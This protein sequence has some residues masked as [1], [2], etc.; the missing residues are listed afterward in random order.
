MRYLP[1]LIL[2]I[3]LAT[4]ALGKTIPN[5]ASANLVLGQSGFTT[6]SV[7]PVASPYTLDAP[8]CV[9]VDPA[10]GKVFVLEYNSCRVLR[11]PSASSLRNGAPAEAVFG[12]PRFSSTASGSGDTG[13]GSLAYSIFFDHRGR[14]WVSVYSQHRVLMYEA[15]STRTSSVLADRVY[16]QPNFTTY[17]TGTT[18]STMINPIGVC[19]DKQDHLWV[20]DYGNNR[21]LRFD[22][23]TDKPSGSAADGVLGQANFNTGSSG[24]S[25]TKLSS[26]GHIAVSPSGS[27]FV[28]DLFNHRIVRF[29]NAAQLVNGAG[30]SAVFGQADFTS[31]TPGTSATKY[32]MPWG[33]CCADDDSIWITELSKPRVLRIS[34]ATTKPTNAA[35][36]GVIGQADFITT[37]PGLD[38]RNIAANPYSQPCVDA[39]S[40]LWLPDQMNNRVLRFPP[41]LTKPGLVVKAVAKKVTKK[42]LKVSG[43]ASDQYGVAKVQYKLGNGAAKTASGT[44]TWSF[45]VTLAEGKNKLTV[46]SIDSVG[47]QSP[48]K[49]IKVKYKPKKKS[50]QKQLATS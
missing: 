21:I 46:W 35:A 16:G 47:N 43:T 32:N 1:S 13:W 17:S 4:A 25:A 5:H 6:N 24:T 18:A 39:S 22:N 12:Q 44:T 29:E 31:N 3:A 48:A 9:T 8:C 38:A 27:L 20:S 26:P 15:A 11:Y 45:N 41:D 10:T 36:D 42:K 37:A 23:I 2:P 33:V 50:S 14:L 40:N 30:A 19:V 34:K 7:S 28:A 49:T